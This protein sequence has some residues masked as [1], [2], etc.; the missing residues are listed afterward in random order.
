MTKKELIYQKF[1][2][3]Q[4]SEGIDTKSLSEIANMSRA[5]L[6]HELNE[7]CKEGKLIKSTGRPVLYFLASP[8]K[9]NNDSQLDLLSKNNISLK[10]AIEQ[11]KASILY[12]PKG[13]NCLILGETGVGKSMFA[14]LMHNYAI[15][16]NVKS[17]DSPFIT[18]NCADYSNNPQLLTSQLFGVKKGAYTG[19]ESDKEGLIEQANGGILFLDEVHRLPPE[20]QEALF[21][22]LDTG[23]FRRIG[24][25][26]T[27]S[28][29]VLIIS[30][31]TED[32]GSALLNTFRR[33]I[34][35]IINIPS[36]KDRTLEERLFLIKSFFKHESIRL[37]KE[38]YVSLNTLRA[39]LSYE[40]T[41]NIGQLKS[42]VQML[43]AKAYSEFL[44]NVRIDVRINSST[45]PSYIKE[46]LYKEKEH[47]VL[48][49]NLMSEEIEFFRFNGNNTDNDELFSSNENTIYDFIE[50]KLEKLK[51]L[52]ISDIDIENIL[53]KDIAKHFQN[54]FSMIS[55]DF[56]K[57]NLLTII[58]PDVLECYDDIVSYI[59]E[60]LSLTFDNN[61][62][63]AFALHVNTLIERVHSRK[64]I[65]NP[66]LDKIR[67]L[68]PVE[69]SIA[70]EVKKML[71]DFLHRPIPIDEAGY[72]TL[73]LIPDVTIKN[74]IPDKVKII[75]IAHG[76]STATSMCNVVNTLLGENYAIPIN[77]PI[78]IPPSKVLEHL[79]LIINENPSD[80]GY[81]LLV[82]MGS[83][84]TFADTIRDEL[85]VKLKII[86][87]AS[88]LHVLEATRKALLGLSLNEIYNDVIMINSYLQLHKNLNNHSVPSNKR[89]IITACLTGEGGSAAIKDFLT[90]NLQYPK[91]L[92]DIICLNCLD[93]NDFIEMVH[94]YEYYN[95]VLFLVSSFPV[96]SL[97]VKQFSMS[98]TISGKSLN[99]MQNLINTK[100]ALSN[101]PMILN[102]NIPNISGTELTDDINLFLSELQTKLSIHLTSEKLV[103]ITLHLSFLI[104]RLRNNEKTVVYPNKENYIKENFSLY[105][106]I[107]ESIIFI[108]NKY[109]IEFTDN[110]ICYLIQHFSSK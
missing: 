60:N 76:E 44:T 96:D 15:E 51:S 55:K 82:D 30:A 72:I 66:N 87:L 9:S 69:F 32:P 84:L 11:A 46:G 92:I 39:L 89:L 70:L 1:L 4:F 78:D 29:D 28:S 68:Y 2:Q 6:S 94:N 110:D 7:L 58:S 80:S 100:I 49:N 85:G 93:K 10:P 52:D 36:L 107:K 43:C 38:L 12:P 90:V 25:S 35:I 33:R 57:K 108:R 104:G 103:G 101:I 14:S 71:E 16:M 86:S 109:N 79:K 17:E 83:L 13:M 75:L 74:N 73:F 64:M 19:A 45:L 34:P 50:N 77:A 23:N 63:T 105:N 42:D 65:N 8:K 3:L 67:N 27:R 26:Q 47:R 102:E 95:E 21:I 98:D 59:S 41:N 62:Y 31:T 88:T 61:L 48:W 56:N 18:F 97:G 20:G 81:L 91:D 53:E 5:N 24:D 106:I 99:E 40:C 37:N 54:N 22:F